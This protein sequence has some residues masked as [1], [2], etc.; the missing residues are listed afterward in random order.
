MTPEELERFL[1]YLPNEERHIPEHNGMNSSFIMY[2]RIE[3]FMP[4]ASPD[5]QHV[6]QV[7][8]NEQNAQVLVATYERESFN[9]PNPLG[10]NSSA[11]QVLFWIRL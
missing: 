5:R 6:I 3:D 11:D 8:K 4:K 10:R 1:H 9:Y 2:S 7:R